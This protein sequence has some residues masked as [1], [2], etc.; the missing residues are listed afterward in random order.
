M[1]EIFV[2]TA[3][4]TKC[5]QKNALI[6]CNDSIPTLPLHTYMPPAKG[7]L[8]QASAKQAANFF[9]FLNAFFFECFFKFMYEFTNY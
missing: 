4:Q 7:N 1:A 2:M 3:R 8:E 9:N 5:P 6:G